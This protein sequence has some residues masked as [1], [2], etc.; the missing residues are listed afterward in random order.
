MITLH[1]FSFF[2]GSGTAH[3]QAEVMTRTVEDLNV[4]ILTWDNSVWWC[5]VEVMMMLQTM[6]I[7]K[8]TPMMM[9]TIKTVRRRR[10]VKE[11]T[12]S[13]EASLQWWIVIRIIRTCSCNYYKG[14][15]WSWWWWFC[16]GL[17]SLLMLHCVWLHHWNIINVFCARMCSQ[18]S[19]LGVYQE[20]LS[21]GQ[22]FP[23]HSLGSR[24]YNA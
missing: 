3:L 1:A 9:M 15:W 17:K 5:N 4:I 10:K 11:V 8:R 2:T 24:E 13:G 19:S 22:Y 18:Y 16:Y 7:T 14:W 20:M 23:I 12:V 6:M 21:L